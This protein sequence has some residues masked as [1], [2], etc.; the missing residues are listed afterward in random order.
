MPQQ[1]TLVIGSTGKTGRRI[2]HR[3]TALGHP[4]RG[5]ARGA[6]PPFDWERPETWPGVLRGAGSVY[7]TYYPDLAA[8]G[9]P[10]AIEAFT[11]L[12]VDAGV[13]RLVLLSGRGEA[14]A[15]RCEQIV[16]ASGLRHTLIRAS[17]FFQNF[18]EGLLLEPVLSGTLAMP[19]GEVGE[20]FIDAD[21]IADV[22]VAVLTGEGHDGRLYELTGPRL[23]TFAEAA[24]EMAKATGRDIEYLAISL[25]QFRAALTAGV[26][27]DQADLLTELCRQVFDGRN[28]SLGH[29]VRE[30]LGRE[31]R[32]F[33]DF[34]RA[35]AASD[36]W[37]RA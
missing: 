27:P 18:T 25:E 28:E 8:P 24:A 33:A 23:L 9:A 14:D 35:A 2:A 22:A 29:G 26:G 6:T 31:P 13:Q 16:R 30:V 34:C 17:W 10:A 12:A 21:D 5:A 19:A 4:V 1:P 37:A 3:L 11:A 7:L 36:V 32:D 15:V 20:P